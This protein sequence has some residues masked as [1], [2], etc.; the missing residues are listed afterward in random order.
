MTYVSLRRRQMGT[1][2]NQR[3]HRDV[4][5]EARPPYCR[6][7]FRPAPALEL[8]SN[9]R[10]EMRGN[11]LWR[12]IPQ[13]KRMLLAGAA[14][15]ALGFGLSAAQACPGIASTT[16][17]TTV[18]QPADPVVSTDI[19]SAKKKKKMARKGG[20][21]SKA[22]TGGGAGGDSGSGAASDTQQGK[23]RGNPAVR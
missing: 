13:M 1:R 16:T 2:N 8:S 12:R 19:S 17:S 18:A 10:I 15:A 20:G 9:W 6:R 7:R 14:I 21:A 11:F 4:P 5:M 3:K 23:P 22:G